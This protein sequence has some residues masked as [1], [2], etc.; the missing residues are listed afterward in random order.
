[1][2]NS[3]NPTESY[4]VCEPRELEAHTRAGWEMLYPISIMQEGM[5]KQ[6]ENINGGNGYS[7]TY[8]EVYHAAPVVYF[9][10]RHSKQVDYALEC[11]QKDSTIREQSRKNDDLKNENRHLTERCTD[12][13]NHRKAAEALE[14]KEHELRRKREVD[15]AKVQK[16]FGEK[17]YRE[18]LGQ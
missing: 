7:P 2:Q 1:M 18:A 8:K 15:L 17:A 14:R 13:E 3:E 5:I 11:Q 4:K 12:L 6:R 9:L 10:L 16:H